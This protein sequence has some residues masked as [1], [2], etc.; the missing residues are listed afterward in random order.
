MS[1][2]IEIKKEISEIK[3]KKSCCRTS[4]LLGMII[5]G[6]IIDEKSIII[7]ISSADVLDMILNTLH[8]SKINVDVTREKNLG[9]ETY[10][11]RLESERFVSLLSRIEDC[12]YESSLFENEKCMDFFR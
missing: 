3:N 1:F 6:T 9:L 12:N 8:S 2:S 5:D 11:A 10:T 7:K 4:F